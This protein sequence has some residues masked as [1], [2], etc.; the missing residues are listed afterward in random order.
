MVLVRSGGK[1]GSYYKRLFNP[2]DL[3]SDQFLL[4]APYL[5]QRGKQLL[6]DFNQFGSFD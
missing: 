2:D 3:Y 6:P 4:P 5:K 1:Y